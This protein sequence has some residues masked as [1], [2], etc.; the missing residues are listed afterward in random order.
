MDDTHKKK[1]MHDAYSPNAISN[2]D[3]FF[4]YTQDI[5]SAAQ[6][7]SNLLYGMNH[8]KIGGY[9]PVNKDT[10]GFVFFTRPMLNL[11]DRN[12][13][14]DRTFMN[15]LTED[16]KSV[17]SYVRSTLDP[18]LYAFSPESTQSLMVDP[19][20]SF[21][22]ALSNSILSLSGWPDVVAPVYT[23]KQ[24]VRKEQWSI[25]DG[26]T[27]INE[28][29]DIDASFKNMADEPISML[30]RTWINYAASVF[31]GT[32]V[33]YNG[34]QARNEID[35]TTRIYRLVMDSTETYV[36]KIACTIASFPLNDPTGKFFDYDR[37]QQYMDKTK[38]LNIRFKCMGAL[39][40][41]DIIIKWFNTAG[42]YCNPAINDIVKANYQLANTHSY[43]KIPRALLSKFKHRGYPIINTNTYELEWW[44]DKNSTAYKDV[45]SNLYN[46]AKDSI[47]G[48]DVS[49]YDPVNNNLDKI[50]N[51]ILHSNN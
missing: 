5:G 29:F 47:Y 50:K 48:T 45:V 6:A 4:S 43:D 25:I 9:V 13:Y 18:S 26:T 32:L 16:R 24:G 28:S 19:K 1:I 41:D 8:S 36:K 3:D 12:L 7:G 30:F 46:T 51:K 14:R 31:D 27:E 21:I 42:S 2:L 23:S 39:Y 15:L 11:S 22:P 20:M 33:P 34:M 49:I 40:D 10:Q 44:I 37:K 35:Y 38:E 17:Q